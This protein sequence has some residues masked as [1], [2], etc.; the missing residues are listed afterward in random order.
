MVPFWSLGWHQ[1][2]WGYRTTAQFKEVFRM[3]EEFNIPV[4]AM[5]TDIDYMSD[6]LDFTV[7][8]VRY[9]GLNEFVEDL[10]S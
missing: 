5:W 10:H 6:Y 7:D 8:P 1:S 3:Y 9:D 2:R 4:D